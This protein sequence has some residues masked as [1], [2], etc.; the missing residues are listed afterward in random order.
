MMR[1]T[2]SQPHELYKKRWHIGSLRDYNIALYDGHRYNHN[3]RYKENDIYEYK[4]KDCMAISGSN[5]NHLFG[6]IKDKKYFFQDWAKGNKTARTNSAFWDNLPVKKINHE[7]DLKI[8][9]KKIVEYDEPVNLFFSINAYWHWI[10]EDLPLVKYLRT[11]DYKIITNK[12]TKW[13]KES[14]DYFPD[15]RDR[16][17]EHDTPC[18]I[19]A[20][21]VLA[22]SKPDGGAGRNCRWVIEF[23]CQYLVPSKDIKPTKKIYISRNDAQAR[24]V[25]NETEVKEYL[26][27]R[28]FELYDDFANYS[29]QEKIDIFA[30]SKLTVSPTGANLCHSHAMQP[31]STVIDFNHSFLLHNEH[32]YNNIGDAAGLRWM[33]FAAKTG[34]RNIRPRERNRNLVVD[35]NTLEEH[36]T[37]AGF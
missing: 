22:F 10:M 16:I 37:Y 18:V 32:W 12:L 13:Q 28:G 29:L 25:D 23:L 31:G 19:K 8:E 9:D 6:I 15:V 26:K 2:L 11:N 3:F 36:L 14:L 1:V 4:V 24:A 34:S 21:E 33:T 7:V 17:V 27:N 30:S 35:L 5:T 20:P